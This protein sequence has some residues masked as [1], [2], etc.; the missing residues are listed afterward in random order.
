[1]HRSLILGAA[2]LLGVTMT[3][4]DSIIGASRAATLQVTG[5]VRRADTATPLAGARVSLALWKQDGFLELASTTTGDDGRYVLSHRVQDV[6]TDAAFQDACHVWHEDRTTRVVVRALHTG[7]IWAT[8]AEG[9]EPLM[10]TEAA[11][12]ID[13]VLVPLPG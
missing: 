8:D 10:C 6:V 1:M 7:Y 11:Q 4:C 12:Q 2:L 5:T 3:A 9:L 13:L